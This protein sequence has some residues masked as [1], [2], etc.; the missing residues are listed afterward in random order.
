[1]P[2][3]DKKHKHRKPGSFNTLK[4]EDD[5]DKADFE[6]SKQRIR[7]RNVRKIYEFFPPVNRLQLVREEEKKVES[8][9]SSDVEPVRKS[10]KRKKRRRRGGHSPIDS[11]IKL[12]PRKKQNG[13]VGNSPDVAS[14]S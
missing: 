4:N 9:H 12:P 5:I 8:E 3:K 6:V 14:S 7:S 11:R 1:M 10:K 2:K 13:L